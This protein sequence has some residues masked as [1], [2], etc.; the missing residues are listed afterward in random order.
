MLFRFRKMRSMDP[1]QV[2]MTGV[3]MGERYLQVFCSD[4]ALTRGLATK[5]GLSG[6]AALAAADQSQ[7]TQGRRAAEK[8]GVLLDLQVTPPT[9]LPW[10]DGVFDMVVVDNTGDGFRALNESDRSMSLQECR[11]VLRHGGR[12]EFIERST[13]PS[14]AEA[15]LSA[16]GF[17]P[18]R[19][20]AERDG[21]RFVEGLK[22]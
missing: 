13:E 12:V 6:V 20:L 5:T 10:E 4:T 1:L 7:A 14:V 2:A 11:R 22:G 15:Q 9:R 8:A 21:F 16:A 17:K 19:K 18:V 3:R